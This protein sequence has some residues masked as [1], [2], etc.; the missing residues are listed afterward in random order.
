MFMGSRWSVELAG[1]HSGP[2]IHFSVYWDGACCEAHVKC[3]ATEGC[4]LIEVV[5]LHSCGRHHV[6]YTQKRPNKISSSLEQR[7]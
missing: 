5:L 1:T 7:H 4:I 3:V 6:R 2:E